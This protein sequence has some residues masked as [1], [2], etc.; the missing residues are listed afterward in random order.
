MEDASRSVPDTA[1]L[2]W[3]GC[4]HQQVSV[5]TGLPPRKL[6]GVD[7]PNPAMIWLLA[8]P[9]A[10]EDC[11]VAPVDICSR[12]LVDSVGAVE[13]LREHLKLQQALPVAEKKK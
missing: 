6:V 11:N 4:A 9:G 8:V 7:A 5:G 13:K 1:D 12:R 10:C 3:T 2:L